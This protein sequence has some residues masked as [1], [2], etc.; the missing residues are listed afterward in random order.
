MNDLALKLKTALVAQLR[1][2]QQNLNK[3]YIVTKDN[4]YTRA[5]LATEIENETEFGVKILSDVLMLAI[6]ITSRSK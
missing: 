1:K 3:T 6:D 4:T 5:E 2:N